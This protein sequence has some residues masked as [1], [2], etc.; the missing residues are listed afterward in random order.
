VFHDFGTEFTVF[1]VNSEE[2]RTGIVES[3]SNVLQLEI[4]TGK[5]EIIMYSAPIHAVLR[6][7]RFTLDTF[8]ENLDS[9]I[10]VRI[11]EFEYARVH[12]MIGRLLF[13]FVNSG[14]RVD[15]LAKKCVAILN[16]S[17]YCM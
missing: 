8:M 5:G 12:T 16:R 13:G 3:I 10:M 17:L 14:T 2:P 11:S 6:M 1:D 4:V 15:S 7:T 9:W